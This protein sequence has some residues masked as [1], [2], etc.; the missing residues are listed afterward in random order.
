VIRYV[1]LTPRDILELDLMIPVYIS[2]DSA[3]Y[4][5]NKIDSWR[6]GQPTKIELVKLG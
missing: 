2:Q 1:M 6:K 5:I 4:Y 3:Y